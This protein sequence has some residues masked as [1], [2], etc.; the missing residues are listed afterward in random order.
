MPGVFHRKRQSVGIGKMIAC[1]AAA[2]GGL[3]LERSHYDMHRFVTGCYRVSS[4]KIMRDLRIVLLA[5][6]HDNVFGRHNKALLDAIDALKPDLVLCAG[7]MTTAHKDPSRQ[8]GEEACA[9]LMTLGCRYPTLV[10]NG[11]HE[12]RIDE[13]RHLYG[14]RYDTY[15]ASVHSAGAVILRNERVIF[16]EMGV[17][18][19]GLELPLDYFGH[20]GLKKLSLD[21]I[22]GM[23][24]APDSNYYNIL[25]AHH[26]DYFPKYAEWGADLSVA[27]HVHGGIVWLPGIGG[28]VSPRYLPFPRYTGGMYSK[29]GSSMVVSRGLGMHT[30]P[31]RIFNPCE[32]VFI[33]IKAE[34]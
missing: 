24:G 14:D 6:L 20:F 10:I 18:V 15:E 2:A 32:L 27:G 34:G 19:T 12:T 30:I 8:R 22:K 7:D 26:P 9:L 1:G 17:A 31:L 21:D 29:N 28:L 23:I 13:R 11:N 33:E 5:D 25:I 3:M 4:D 16:P